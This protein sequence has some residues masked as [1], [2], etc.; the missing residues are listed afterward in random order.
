MW[1]PSA[2][3]YA[4]PW[5]KRHG[6]MTQKGV[7]CHSAE[8]SRSGLLSEIARTSRGD[9]WHFS[10][11][12]DGDIYQ[13]YPIDAILYHAADTWGNNN[14]IG[15]EH[16]GVADEPLSEPQRTAS[17]T[18]VRWLAEQGKY[19]LTRY[20][21][22]WEHRELSDTGTECPS[23][24]IPW[25]YYFTL[26]PPL[27]SYQRTIMESSATFAGLGPMRFTPKTDRPGYDMTPR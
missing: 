8:G 1:F 15:I 7:V 14:L 26:S 18:L 21:T 17:V 5:W 12:K 20:V 19:K 11:M 6:T 27:T 25:S 10:V 2:I 22:T 4:G 16:E 23:G 3:V 9:A 13:H 24:R